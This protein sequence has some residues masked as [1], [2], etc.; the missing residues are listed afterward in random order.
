MKIPR[1]VSGKDLV[2]RLKRY[3]YEVTKKTGGHIRL[4]TYINGKHNV[5]IPA[6]ETIKVGTLNNIL[7]DLAKHLEVEKKALLKELF[8]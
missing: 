1:D 4:T 8:F 5:T 7:N 3:N 2:D 6:H